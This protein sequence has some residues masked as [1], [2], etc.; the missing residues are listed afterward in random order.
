MIKVIFFRW[1]CP[2]G[3]RFF[4]RKTRLFQKVVNT[5]KLSVS[6]GCQ[7]PEI[8]I[9]LCNPRFVILT[10]LNS[11]MVNLFSITL[12]INNEIV[13][14]LSP[15]QRIICLC[16][17]SKRLIKGTD[18]LLRT[19]FFTNFGHNY[20]FLFF[21]GEK[22][23]SGYLRHVSQNIRGLRVPEPPQIGANI[24]IIYNCVYHINIVIISK[25]K[26]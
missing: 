8:I 16:M 9:K 26:S 19:W 4:F 22:K 1:N 11:M 17:M 6:E 3:M 5:Q 23:S 2:V 14:M 12:A 13:I 15:E 20:H 18:P 21:L 10:V 7:H 25:N 24:Y